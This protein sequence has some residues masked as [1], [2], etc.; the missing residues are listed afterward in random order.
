MKLRELLLSVHLKG[1]WQGLACWSV[2]KVICLWRE[3]KSF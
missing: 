1:L 3:S 2:T